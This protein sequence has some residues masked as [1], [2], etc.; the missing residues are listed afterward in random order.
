ME[1]QPGRP[2]PGPSPP[3]H[4]TALAR[5]PPPLEQL[6]GVSVT[7]PALADGTEAQAREAALAELS[8][9]DRAALLSVAST[10]PW[11][12]PVRPFSCGHHLITE[13][14]HALT[15]GPE[16]ELANVPG[17]FIHAAAELLERMAR[18]V[19]TAGGALADGQV[20]ALDGSRAMVLVKAV[21]SEGAE[22]VT[23]TPVLR[24][25]LLT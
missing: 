20:I 11:L 7:P 15:G 8:H 14:L 17:P 12:D 23:P 22:D 19:L 10:Q 16:L 25:V 4:D 1:S 2:M 18:Y 24:L 21:A 9:G 13:G 3:E 5:R 6:V